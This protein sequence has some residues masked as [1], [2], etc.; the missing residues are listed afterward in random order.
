MF[1]DLPTELERRFADDL[2]GTLRSLAIS[3]L[4]KAV[5]EYRA[6]ID[7]QQPP[8]DSE[9]WRFAAETDL[10]RATDVLRAAGVR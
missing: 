1:A 4:R 3:Y 2:R 9:L 5:V 6:C 8:P 7:A 10:R